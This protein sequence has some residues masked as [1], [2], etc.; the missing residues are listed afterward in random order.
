MEVY[1][2]ILDVSFM[3]LNISL[4]SVALTSIPYGHAAHANILMHKSTYSMFYL[5]LNMHF[6]AIELLTFNH[7]AIERRIKYKKVSCFSL[8][9]TRESVVHGILWCHTINKQL[10]FLDTIKKILT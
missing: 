8:T 5:H 3:L 2:C 6:A 4:N 7:D 10:Q 9:F 1:D